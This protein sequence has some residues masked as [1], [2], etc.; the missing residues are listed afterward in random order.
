[1][2]Y[3]QCTLNCAV[4][5]WEYEKKLS[6]ASAPPPLPASSSFPG[7]IF[8][9]PLPKSPKS[10]N[11][12]NCILPSQ[13]HS[14]QQEGLQQLARSGALALGLLKLDSLPILLVRVLDPLL[15]AFC[16]VPESATGLSR[17]CACLCACFCSVCSK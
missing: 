3:L 10:D 17:L 1:M 6:E 12:R 16:F 13:K 2:E 7:R 4:C 5:F 8:H 9:L 15:A 14:K 11:I